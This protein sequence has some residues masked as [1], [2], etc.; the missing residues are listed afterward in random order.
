MAESM[1]GL[2]HPDSPS[3]VTSESNILFFNHH[4]SPP[5]GPSSAGGC[6]DR[7]PTPQGPLRGLWPG[8]RPTPTEHAYREPIP[9]ALCP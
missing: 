4:K 5:Q 2:C 3:R 7:V 9:S 8:L 6:E 1:H